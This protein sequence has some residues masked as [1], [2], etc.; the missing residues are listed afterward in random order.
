MKKVILITG[1]SSELGKK[2]V[3]KFSNDGDIVY[4][5]TRNTNKL[6]VNRNRI[7]AIKLDITKPQIAEAFRLD[8]FLINLF[9]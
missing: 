9:L 1:G 4:M 7:R 5:A 6:E 3:E 8:I 2:I